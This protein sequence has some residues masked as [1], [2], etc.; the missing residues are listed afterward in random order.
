M[1]SFHKEIRALKPIILIIIILKPWG[2]VIFIPHAYSNHRMSTERDY[3]YG[4]SLRI[5]TLMLELVDRLD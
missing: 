4:S 3:D 1:G 5:F 2:I